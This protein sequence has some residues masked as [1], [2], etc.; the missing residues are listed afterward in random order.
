MLVFVLV[1]V[2]YMYMLKGNNYQVI[3]LLME[4]STWIEV[5]YGHCDFN[6]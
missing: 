3:C 5:L 1:L 4:R 2:Y 6:D